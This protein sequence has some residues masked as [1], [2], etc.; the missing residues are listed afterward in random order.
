MIEGIYGVEFGGESRGTG[1]IW[2][3]AGLTFCCNI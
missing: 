1:K 2:V 3:V